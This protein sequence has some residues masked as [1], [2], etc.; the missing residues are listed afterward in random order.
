MFIKKHLI[1]F[2]MESLSIRQAEGSFIGIEK[3]LL[4]SLGAVF[5]HLVL[6]DGNGLLEDPIGLSLF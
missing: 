4:Y 3:G 1:V 2:S 6:K 5:G